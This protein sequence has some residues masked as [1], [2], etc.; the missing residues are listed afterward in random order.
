MCNIYVGNVGNHI[1]EKALRTQ[2]EAYGAVERVQ[3][4]WNS[5]LIV[6]A[7]DVAAERA[8]SEMTA[9]TTWV[10]RSIPSNLSGANVA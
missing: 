8:I 5:A 3:M 10:V 2:F 9:R 6:M 4:G 7:N 1:T